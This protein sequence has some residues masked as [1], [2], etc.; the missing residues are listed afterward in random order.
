[1]GPETLDIDDNP[2]RCLWA[3]PT[4]NGWVSVEYKGVPL[5]KR[6]AGHTGFTYAATRMTDGA[7]VTLEVFINGKKVLTHVNENRKGWNRFEADTSSLAGSTGDV[8]FRVFTRHDG[9]RHFC[10]DALATD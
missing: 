3:H 5:S 6:I 7:P 4:T 2:R 1:V 10:F 9:M 8:L